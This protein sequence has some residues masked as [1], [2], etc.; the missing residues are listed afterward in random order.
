MLVRT[1]VSKGQ[2]VRVIVTMAD[3]PAVVVMPL[4]GERKQRAMMA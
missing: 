3:R 4:F 1:G 2:F